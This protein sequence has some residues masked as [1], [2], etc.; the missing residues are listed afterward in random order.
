VQI[1][2]T[3]EGVTGA[4]VERT[5]NATDSEDALK[6]LPSLLVRKRYIGDYNHA[7]LSTRASGT[8]NSARSMVYADGILL[9]NFLGNGAG[10]TPRWAMVTPEE[11]ERVD[12]LYGPFS[13]AY[14]GNAVGAVVDYVTRMP[15]AFTAHVKLGAS[16]QHFRL[17]GTDER[18]TGRQRSLSL[19]DRHGALAW[20][21]SVN[22]LDS[23]GQPLV[24]ATRL[25]SEGVAP[26]AGTPVVTGAIA[27]KN[28]RNQDWW[29]LGTHTGYRTVQ[30][31][32]KL[33]LAYDI[34]PTLRASYTYGLWDNASDGDADSYL[35]DAQGRPVY[36]GNVVIGGRQYNLNASSLAFTPTRNTLRHSMHGLSLKSHTRGEWDGE[37]TASRYDYDSDLLRTPA[38]AGTLGL[39]DGAGRITDMDGTGWNTL[40]ARGIWR[41]DGTH[42]VEFGVQR[43]AYKLHT[44]V[45]T[46]ADWLNGAAGARFSSFGGHTR[47]TSVYLQ[48]TWR[49]AS[50]WKATL[51]WREEAW[52]AWGGELGNARAVVPFGAA[53]S[54]THGSPKAAVAWRADEAWTLKAS[55]GRAWRMPTVSE[56]YQGSIDGDTI[57]NTNQLLRPERSW[58]GELSAERSVG[59]ALLR[60]TAFHERT[61][62][63]LYAQSL[64]ATVS[65]VQNVD[66]IRTGGLELA[67]QA[68]L[69][70]VRGLDL[71]GSVT[72][73]ASTI[74]ANAGLPASVGKRQPRVPKWR[75]AL[76]ATWQPTARLSWTLGA[77]YSGTQYGQLDN[78]DTHAASYL[79]FS[80]YTVIDTRVRYK[81]DGGWSVAGGIDN[82]GDRTYWAFHPYPQRTLLL[83]LRWD[84]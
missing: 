35:R 22:R 64:T 29:I 18:D 59:A 58:T 46:T 52:R 69:A 60:A 37:L 79:G 39:P 83:E 4:Q 17:Y 32:A 9:S 82:L 10:F 31:H 11:I 30:D 78:S 28:N 5:I 27:D 3:M 33:K 24:F 12:V 49:F 20:W 53:R 57:V 76:L 74:A 56:L 23:T 34:T 50:D 71:Q 21:F 8:G 15:T 7:V 68:P 54:E 44:L 14:A 73:T 36:G 25:L 38:V 80:P 1:P 84:K 66:A 72:Y 47:L 40:H 67:A 6:Y 13:A 61:R 43:E 45:S 19:G 2:A 81:F 16:T 63:A 77:R 55:L 41:P 51:G 70:F 62:D 65:T 48:D 26:T 75:A 42:L